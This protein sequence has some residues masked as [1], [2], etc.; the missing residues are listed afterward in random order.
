MW[1]H[2]FTSEGAVCWSTTRCRFVVVLGISYFRTRLWFVRLFHLV[3]VWYWCSKYL[4]TTGW[5]YI[6]MYI[7][8]C[9]ILIC[10]ELHFYIYNSIPRQTKRTGYTF[11][12][13]QWPAKLDEA[14]STKEVRSHFEFGFSEKQHNSQATSAVKF[15][16]WSNISKSGTNW[17]YHDKS[18]REKKER[19]RERTKKRFR[20][21]EWERER[22]RELLPPRQTVAYHGSPPTSPKF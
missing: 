7:C 17:G 20:E 9:L 22:Q 6:Y 21:R 12:N 1:N 4:S 10:I 8:N 16:T 13:F 14:T 3:K 5:L 15:T 2:P 11:I 19:E 18:Q